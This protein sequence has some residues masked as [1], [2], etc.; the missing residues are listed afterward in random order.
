MALFDLPLSVGAPCR[1]CGA[2]LSLVRIARPPGDGS[3][4]GPAH[5]ACT[6]Q[7]R[8]A[9]V[10]FFDVDRGGAVNGARLGPGQLMP[11]EPGPPLPPV[12]HAETVAALLAVSGALRE[13]ADAA[14][15]VT[16]PTQLSERMEDQIARD[17]A[18]I[19]VRLRELG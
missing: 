18:A 2:P 6:G 13:I 1:T 7:E 10:E 8:H 5:Y 12:V 9:W 3:P 14:A 17:L 16:P 4:R 15:R 19:D 11:W